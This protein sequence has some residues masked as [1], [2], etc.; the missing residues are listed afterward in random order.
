MR[1]PLMRRRLEGTFSCLNR[2]IIFLPIIYTGVEGGPFLV[3]HGLQLALTP[4]VHPQVPHD[5]FKE[6][7]YGLSVLGKRFHEF[8][9]YDLV[10]DGVYANPCDGSAVP[11]CGDA[12]LFM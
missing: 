7:A 10:V 9:Q 8:G 1:F 11:F 12:Q 4:G 3:Q 2:T 5:L 6:G